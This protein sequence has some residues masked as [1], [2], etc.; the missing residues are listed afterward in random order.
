[1][2]DALRL[3][4]TTDVLVLAQLDPKGTHVSFRKDEASAGLFSVESWLAC[5]YGNQKP[6]GGFQLYS[7]GLLDF[8]AAEAELLA[9]YLHRL[10]GLE[11]SAPAGPRSRLSPLASRTG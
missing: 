1:M 2:V 11:P 3:Q 6:G 7:A 10:L 5:E 9:T 4:S 8:S